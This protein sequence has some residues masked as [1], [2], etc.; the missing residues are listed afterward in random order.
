MDH[1]SAYQRSCEI[2][3]ET[4][5]AVLSV[6]EVEMARASEKIISCA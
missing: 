2:A 3:N 4:T 1:F 6:T 5:C